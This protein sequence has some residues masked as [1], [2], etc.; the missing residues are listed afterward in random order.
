MEVIHQY[1][2]LK[3]E[4]F[5]QVFTNLF[6]RLQIDVITKLFARWLIPS[7]CP[8]FCDFVAGWKLAVNTSYIWIQKPK[9]K[10][11]PVFPYAVAS[12][13][14]TEYLW[15]W[16]KADEES[17]INPWEK[18]ELCLWKLLLQPIRALVKKSV[19]D[20]LILFVYLFAH[21]FSPKQR[22]TSSLRVVFP[23]LSEHKIKQLFIPILLCKDHLVCRRPEIH[24]HHKKSCESNDAI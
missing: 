12:F 19:P 21:L 20:L 9:K 14:S 1:F 16:N 7:S 4:N 18:A 2:Y 22:M 10:S 13:L 8:I 17:C 6:I 3:P 5:L 11:V 23:R 24:M 15:Q